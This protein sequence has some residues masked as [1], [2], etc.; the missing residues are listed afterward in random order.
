MRGR[1]GRVRVAVAAR[2]GAKR[3]GV[4]GLHGDALKLAVQ[5]PAQKGK[6]NAALAALLAEVLGVAPSA[7]TLTGGA[8]ARQKLFEVEATLAEVDAALRAALAD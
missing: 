3:P 2:P 7:V 1:D 8:S 4:Q 6:A 5:A